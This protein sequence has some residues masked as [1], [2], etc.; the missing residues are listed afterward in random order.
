MAQQDISTPDPAGLFGAAEPFGA[1]YYKLLMEQYKLYVDSSTKVSERRATAQTFFLTANTLLAS[2]YGL[3]AGRGVAPAAAQAGAA[4]QWLVPLAGLLLALSWFVLIGG[5]A[6]LNGSKFKVIH[7]LEQRLPARLFDR[8]WHVLREKKGRLT[9]TQV[10]R[11]I[12]LIFALFFAALMVGAY[13]LTGWW[14]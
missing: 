6:A 9:L 14:S 7:E 5:Y 2:V 13:P 1:D 11:V 3:A 4:W 8:E 10:E 12:P